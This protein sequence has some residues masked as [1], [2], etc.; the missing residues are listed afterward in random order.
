MKAFKTVK[1][2]FLV[3][4]TEEKSEINKISQIYDS[5]FWESFSTSNQSYLN[6]VSLQPHFDLNLFWQ[7]FLDFLTRKR[8][9]TL[10]NEHEF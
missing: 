2:Y 9:W 8:S 6:S 5:N 3:S 1:N 10:V 7:L 4:L